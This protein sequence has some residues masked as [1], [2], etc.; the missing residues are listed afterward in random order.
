MN[1]IRHKVTSHMKNE[2][3]PWE[4]KVGDKFRHEQTRSDGNDR[5]HFVKTTIYQPEENQW[6]QTQ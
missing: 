6:D 5:I 1:E 4:E 3:K 2:R